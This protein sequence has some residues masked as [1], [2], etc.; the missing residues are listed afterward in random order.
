M[1]YLDNYI[2][3]FVTSKVTYI[4][5]Y[6]YNN[7]LLNVGS[8]LCIYIPKVAAI[9]DEHSQNLPNNIKPPPKDISCMDIKN[10]WNIFIHCSKFLVLQIFWVVFKPHQTKRNIL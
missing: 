4:Y 3:S 5:K 9:V 2:K 6:I 8:I 10:Q 1:K 7:H